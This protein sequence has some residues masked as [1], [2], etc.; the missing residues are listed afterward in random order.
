ME[1]RGIPYHRS[2]EDQVIQKLVA[3]YGKQRWNFL[4]R[5]MDELL[6]FQGRTGK[7]CRER[8]YN[9]LNPRIKKEPWKKEEE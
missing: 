7:Q 4:A 3:I 6:G 9:H 1:T 8:W 5:S 2:Q